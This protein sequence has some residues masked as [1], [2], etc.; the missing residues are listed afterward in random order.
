[1]TPANELSGP[2]GPVTIVGLVVHHGRPLAGELASDIARWLVGNGH[3]ARVLEGDAK[4]IAGLSRWATPQSSFAA[5]LHLAISIGGDGTMLRAIR[6]VGATGTPVLGVNVGHL[7]YL[8]EVE[9]SG[10][11]EALVR[12]LAGD[13]LVEERMTLCVE[14][15]R[16]V[17]SGSGSS[18][19]SGPDADTERAPH[20]AE[21]ALNDAVVEKLEAGH[22]VRV[23]V[24]ISGRPAIGYATDALIVATP[25]GS[26][27]YNLSAGGPLVSPR[28]EALLV[29]PVAPHSLFGR[30]MVLA[31][32]E[33]VEIEVLAGSAVLGVD[34]RPLGPLGVGDVVRCQAGPVPARLVTFGERE[35]WRI[36]KTKF[37]LHG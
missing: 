15:V 25:T 34:G 19:R 8:T 5:G 33:I 26:T 3:G 22:T 32:D 13:H 2:S 16:A 31:R 24:T 9:P 10:W 37:G 14:V 12:I 7:G 28:L 35:F 21:T 27:A 23:G 20:V 1:M 11:R 4:A 30:A 18:D 6:L 29:T 17:R 36:L